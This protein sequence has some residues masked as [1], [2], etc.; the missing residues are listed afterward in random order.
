MK[1]KQMVWSGLALAGLVG[2]I[3]PTAVEG[4]SEAELSVLQSE[5]TLDSKL[6]GILSKRIDYL[7]RTR[8]TTDYNLETST[9]FVGRIGYGLGR[10]FALISEEPTYSN[11][12]VVATSFT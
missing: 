4:Q 1:L 2:L 3:A 6:I 9:F 5:L 11:P 7:A 10:G 12:A 8:A